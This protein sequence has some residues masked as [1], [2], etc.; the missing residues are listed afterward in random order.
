MD[1]NREQTLLIIAGVVIATILICGVGSLFIGLFGAARFVVA[2]AAIPVLPLATDIPL[3][4]TPSSLTFPDYDCP[5][6]TTTAVPPPATAS[7][8][9]FYVR[10]DGIYRWQEATG[11][12]DLIFPASDVHVLKLSDDGQRLAFIRQKEVDA[13]EGMALWVMDSDGKN[14]RE[15]L[16]P[17]DFRTLY[18]E[19]DE[20]VL[21]PW[22]ITWQPYSH[23][24]AFSAVRYNIVAGYLEGI[25]AHRYDDLHLIDADSGDT[26]TLLPPGAGGDFF[27]APDGA[28][29]ALVNDTGLSLVNSDGSNL[30]PGI[31]TWEPLGITHEY[32]RPPPAW[33]P[34]SKTLLIA[35]S[36]ATDNIDADYNPDASSTIW[37][38]PVE[39][40]PQSLTTM[41]GAPLWLAFSPDGN[42]V[43]FM[44]TIHE[45]YTR[46]LHI[47]AVDNAWNIVY[48]R[49][50]G[51]DFRG[52][53]P[54]SSGFVL[55]VNREAPL[56]GRLCQP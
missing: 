53:L 41:V 33:L 32:H 12:S 47:A 44:R 14:G 37:R 34:T 25:T 48:A 6:V 3:S 15:L 1:K 18:A 8:N 7:T 9:V 4:P 38:V 13:S 35:P 27:Y 31:L 54:D 42:Q 39:G 23:T 28:Q 10:A 17:A 16:S 26:T 43:A 40:K 24:L 5:V 46:D 51:A 22:L 2:P 50:E 49:D 29:I 11:E 36:N 56:L 52:W 55:G 45:P 30:R 19:T 21:Q 20:M